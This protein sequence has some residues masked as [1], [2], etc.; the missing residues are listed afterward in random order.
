MATQAAA[1]HAFSHW[2]GANTAVR[3][4]VHKCSTVIKTREQQISAP[5]HTSGSG[6][7]AATSLLRRS[8]RCSAAPALPAAVLGC[9]PRV[10]A[11]R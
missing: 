8:Y 1:V 4:A 9:P 7:L 5:S 10:A 2:Q 6:R 11:T 3:H